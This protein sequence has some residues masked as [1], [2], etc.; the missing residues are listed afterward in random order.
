MAGNVDP[1]ACL[2]VIERRLDELAQREFRP[3]ILR[4]AARYALLGPGKRIRPVL[5]WHACVAAG[6]RGDE[7]LDAGAAVEMVHAFSL[8]H[9]D[10][11]ALDDDD[12]RR[13]R[14]TLH[15]RAGEGMAILAGDALLAAAFHV[16]AAGTPDAGLATRLT[17]ELSEA[18][19]NMIAGQVEDSF[20]GARPPG[21]ARDHVER[22]H[23][24]KTGAL[25][26]AA[27][28]MGA[29]CAAACDH[30]DLAAL[31]S[32]ADAVG[33]L[34]Q[35]TDDLLDVEHTTEQ[36][37]KRTRKDADAG[38]LTY[39]GLL[40]VEESHRLVGELSEKAASALA[41]LGARADGLRAL[42]ATLAF[43]ER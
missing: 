38:K 26:R 28:R 29:M 12:L 32:C 22:I 16:L 42:C 14:P 18:A 15:R 7:S 40:G 8:V 33:L 13:G 31:T 2:A 24:G 10:L 1:Y 11:P 34:Y 35:I 19:A 37:G 9:D 27:C 25:I 3:G 43:R 6:G 21:D 39:P 36:A 23:R 5:A 20:P 4:D 41:P 17:R 30:A